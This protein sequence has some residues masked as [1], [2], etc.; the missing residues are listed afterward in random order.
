MREADDAF[1]A[2]LVLD[3]DSL[4]GVAKS[5]SGLQDDVRNSSVFSQVHDK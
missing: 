2:M 4:V 1:N 3:V 5:Q